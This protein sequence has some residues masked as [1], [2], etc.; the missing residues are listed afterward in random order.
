MLAVSQ[1]TEIDKGNRPKKRMYEDG[2]D[3][4]AC[5]R[6]KTKWARKHEVT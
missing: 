1:W 3:S 6:C 2:Y 4:I 5:Q